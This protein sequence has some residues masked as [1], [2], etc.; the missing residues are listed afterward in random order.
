MSEDPVKER[1]WIIMPVA[2]AILFAF[3]SA[4]LVLF[5]TVDTLAGWGQL[6]LIKRAKARRGGK[7]K[8]AAER[9]EER[10][11]VIRGERAAADAAKSDAP[12]PPDEADS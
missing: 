9:A 2:F 8:T 6:V 1:S 10:V 11:E 5:W 3:F 4:G 12:E 7:K